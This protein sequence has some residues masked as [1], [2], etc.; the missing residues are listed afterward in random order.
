[1]FSLSPSLG[2][3]SLLSQER[4]LEAWLSSPL[5]SIV[6]TRKNTTLKLLHKPI[7]KYEN[8]IK[9]IFYFRLFKSFVTV[10]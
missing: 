9:K 1:M 6:H 2:R 8:F 4:Q 10:I 7:R 5:Q 3:L